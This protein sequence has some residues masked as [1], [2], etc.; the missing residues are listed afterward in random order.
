MSDN[1]INSPKV[2]K[3]SS[4]SKVIKES[5]SPCEEQGKPP[6]VRLRMT[7]TSGF[8]VRSLCHDL[9][10]AV[11]ST[12]LMAELKRT[13]QGEYQIG[14]NTLEYA[15]LE[16]GEEVWGPKVERWLRDWQEKNP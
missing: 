12:A 13:R 6:A 2:E 10:V 3:G 16:R 11:N 9:G 15:D 7:V 5:I 8:Y 4:S 14:E 1:S